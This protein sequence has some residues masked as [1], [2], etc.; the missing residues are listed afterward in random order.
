M[1]TYSSTNALRMKKKDL[2]WWE[3]LRNLQETCHLDKKKWEKEQNS[4]VNRQKCMIWSMIIRV[5]V[6]FVKLYQTMGG[7][8][9][10]IPDWKVWPVPLKGDDI[11]EEDTLSWASNSS[12]HK[13]KGLIK[14][15]IL[16]YYHYYQVTTTNWNTRR[17]RK[18][19]N[20]KYK[21]SPGI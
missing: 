18:L 5:F 21:W 9:S 17:R 14:L 16:A 12:W 11:M 13:T 3:D 10:W 8:R 7:A 1:S 20:I 2:P 6:V 15:S 19:N 4:D